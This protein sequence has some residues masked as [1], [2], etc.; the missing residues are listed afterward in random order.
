[1]DIKIKLKLRESPVEYKLAIYYA[2]LTGRLNEDRL[3]NIPP[4][5]YDKMPSNKEHTSK[6]APL[7]D[8]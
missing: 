4:E 1:M 3:E 5:V 8:Y 7:L 2:P 6:P